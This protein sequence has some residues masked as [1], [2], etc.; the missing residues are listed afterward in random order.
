MPTIGLL[1][2]VMLGRSVGDALSARL[3]DRPG[4]VWSDDLRALCDPLDLIVCNLECCLSD[5]GRPTTRIRGKPFFFRGP[6]RAVEALEAIGVR[7][8][9][10]ANNHALDYEEAP[11]VDTLSQLDAAGIAAAG[12]G[13]DRE[14][15]R[16]AAVVDAD[17]TR[18]GLVCVSDH[19]REYAA[20]AD[21][22]GI[23]HADLRDGAP[24]WLLNQVA[25]VAAACD[26]VIAFPHWGPNMNDS[27]LAWQRRVASE[28][29]AA[30]A[31]LVAGH[32]AH[33]FHGVGWDER[34]P[35]L[36]DL[37]DALDDYRIDPVLRNDLGLLAIWTPDAGDEELELVGLRLDFCRTGLA[38]GPDADWIA[39]R[40][41]R[42][43]APLGTRPERLAEGRF[44]ITRAA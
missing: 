41:A 1:G 40:L 5:R 13:P 2:D 7:A 26:A 21:A 42:A 24:S 8:V 18:L 10:L 38:T 34:G 30:G 44:R 28:L 31:N 14:R 36:T 16:R 27:P 33:V 32:S 25:E 19:P 11:L 43:C 15:A 3:A 37:G 29:L 35:V 17:G 23:A 22:P 4:E 9:S 6:P 12:A 39:V 20:T